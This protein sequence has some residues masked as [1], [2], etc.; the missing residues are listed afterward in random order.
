MNRLRAWLLRCAGIFT[1]KSRE[2]EMAEELESHLQMHIADNLRSGMSPQEA[3]RQALVALGGVENTKQAYRDR[4]TIPW[5]ES[6]MQDL[7][8]ARRQL[9]QHPGFAVIAIVVL[10]LGI[11]ACVAIFAFVDAALLKPLPYWQPD[12]LDSVTE[13]VAMIPRANLSYP[14]YLDWKSRNHVYSSL[15]VYD[16]RGYMLQTHD[17]VKLVHGSRVSDG[18]FRTL[19]VKPLLGRDFYSGEDLPSAPHTVALSYSGWQ[20]WFGGRGDIIGQPVTLSGDVYTVVAVLPAGFHFAP[21][22][23][24]EFWTTLHVKGTCDLRRSCHSLN[25]VGRLKDGVSTEKAQAE[26]KTIAAQ[27]EQQY[28]DSNRGQGAMIEP[29]R[30]VIVG[31]VRPI[32]LLLLAGAGLLL[33]IACVN[34]ASLLLVRSESRRREIAVRGALGASRSRLLGLFLTEGLVLVTI[35][36][37]MGLLFAALAIKVLVS[38][39]SEDLLAYMPYLVGLGISAR[40]LAFAAMLAALAL[41]LFTLAP[42]VR[43]LSAHPLTDG[44]TDGGRT[45]ASNTWRRFASRLVVVELATALVLL[46]GAGLLGRSLYRLLHVDVGFQPEHLATVQVALPPSYAKDEQRVAVMRQI[47]SRLSAMPGVTSVGVTTR[48]PVS[49]NGN[50]TWIRFVGR[51]YHGEHNEVNEREVSPEFFRTLQARLLRGRTFTDAEDAT[52]PNVAIINRALAKQYFPNEDPIGKQYGNTALEPKSLTQII[53]VVDDIKEGGLDEQTWPAVYESFN[54]S[55]DDFFTVFVR[56]QQ[57]EQTLLPVMISAIH[58]IDPGIAAFDEMTM[59]GRIQ[60][61]PSAYIHRT[62]A[63]IVGSFAA[64]ALL[65][66]VVGLYGVVAYSVSQR[67]REIGVR[68]ALGAQRSSVYQLILREA[69]WLTL[70]G[71]LSGLVAA[72]AAGAL[73][74]KLLFGIHSWDIPTLVGVAAL[75]TI[76][77]LLA[78]YIPARRAASVNPVDALRT[79]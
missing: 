18:F 41:L 68:M 64:L 47:I 58:Q 53:G 50:T 63:W 73:L 6:L 37:G 74:R 44:L 36:A 38:L 56:S 13:S 23:S 72:V 10:A 48:V 31:D 49:S 51:P 14:D 17:G 40:S 28:P 59:A 15:D 43:F 34:V 67:T 24:A 39:I 19:G 70:L 32:L 20:K 9:Y 52:K 25:G 57:A 71:V 60:N 4:S 69:G 66:G 2:H 33:L 29:L 3:R 42:A 16:Q 30:E 5:I 26:M 75:L 77:A 65:L 76:S 21:A 45:A 22:G 35:G 78:S 12:R 61:S 8:F 79:E 27:L 7:R 46:A 62:S 11:G 1:G 54:Q 55:P